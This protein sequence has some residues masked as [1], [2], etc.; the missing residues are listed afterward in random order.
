MP[1]NVSVPRLGFLG[2]SGVA[3][4]DAAAAGFAVAAGVAGAFFAAV[5]G[6]GEGAWA[7]TALAQSAARR[8]T[9]RR[10]MRASK[11]EAILPRGGP[12]VRRGEACLARCGTP[13]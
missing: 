3:A 10:V 1:L 8:A 6:D 7:K 4:G 11:G 12:D 5:E 13:G 2:A 9:D